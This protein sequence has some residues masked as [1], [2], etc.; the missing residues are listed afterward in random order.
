LPTSIENIARIVA[1]QSKL[2]KPANI[3][4]LLMDSRKLTF[5][6]STLFFAITTTNQDGHVYIKEL[7]QKGVYNFVVHTHFDTS[8][9]S[10]INFIVVSDVVE[11]LQKIAAAHRTEFDY[12]VIGI[13]GSNGKTIVKE[14]LAQL[15]TPHHNIVRSPRSYNSQIGVPLSVWEMT[16]QHNF[17]IFEAGISQKGEMEALANVIQPTIGILTNIGTAH[18]AGFASA[19]EKLA[20]KCILFQKASTIIVPHNLIQ[21]VP[22][23]PDQKI[24]TW[25]YDPLATLFIQQVKI[26][27]GQVEL[28]GIYNKG[29]KKLIAPFVDKIAIENIIICWAA[30]LHLGIS[31]VAIQEGVLQLRHLEMRMQIRKAQNSC[32]LLN[33]SY[34]N[35]LSSLALALDYAKQQ[36]G[37]SP[38]TLILSD[39]LNSPAASLVKVVELLVAYPI[40]KLI[41][42]GPNLSGLFVQEN[43]LRKQGCAIYCYNSTNEYLSV[44]EV[45]DFKEEFIV[46][47][48]AR[49][50]EFE[51]INAVLQLQ[52]HQ[53]RLEVNLTSLANNLKYIRQLTG[54]NV[55]LMAMVKAFGYGSGSVEVARVLQ[56]HHADYLAVAYADEGIELRKAGIHLPIMVMNVDAAAF[57][58]LVQFHL[59][60]EIFSVGLLTE[61][62]QFIQSQAL[63]NFPIHLKLNTGMNRLGF[64]MDQIQFVCDA[65]KQQ[66]DLKVQTIFSHLSASGQPNF[67]SF[68]NEQLTIFKQAAERIEQA[69]GYPVGKHIANS[70]A[71]A[72]ENKF[73][74]SMVRLGIGL[75]GI[76]AGKLE[77]VVQFH[78]T[79]AQIR[80]V[81][82]TETVGYNRSGKLSRDSIIATVRLGYADGYSRQL[83]RSKGS[84]WVQGKLAPVVGDV[85]MDMTMIDITDIAG[86]QEGDDVEVF[87]SNLPIE[88]VANWA[89]TIPY[90][91]LTSIGQRVK[92]VYI[93]D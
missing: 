69:L 80:K 79:I 30:L 3:A 78:T 11:A 10:Q 33:D 35:D 57:D 12:P 86:V 70:G 55:K 53:T 19:K 75:Y 48:G 38:I 5:P 76:G 62:Q 1:T 64:D 44:I 39:F 29:T 31:E 81:A 89:E 84:M 26:N 82:A 58:A 46:L 60:P 52:V 40:R 15:L 66:S 22:N 65:L 32:Y 83:G 92:R 74:L 34:S 72:M 59:E 68:T 25:G 27:N 43:P 47:K 88:Q 21:E 41:T 28:T 90:E 4:Y 20:E 37:N 87:G 8:S 93:Q 54:P 73:H 51:K 2:G 50:F 49:T 18:E 9:Y 23:V 61:F 7:V 63:H 14:W 6:G 71:I 13:T 85:C 77:T 16:S 56:F 17:A 36:A 45:A 67:A 91:I 42:I 24:I